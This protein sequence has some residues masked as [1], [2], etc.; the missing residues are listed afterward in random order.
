[1]LNEGV[2]M[3]RGLGVRMG[4][5]PKLVKEKAL[6]ECHLSSDDSIASSSSPPRIPSAYITSSDFDLPLIVEQVS[7]DEF[8]ALPSCASYVL[9]ANF[10]IDETAQGPVDETINEPEE[11]S[12]DVIECI[13][14][15]VSHPTAQTELE[16]EQSAF[17]RYLRR[18]MFDLCQT[19][20]GRTRQLID[21]MNTMIGLGVRRSYEH[22]T[23]RTCLSFSARFSTFPAITRRCKTS[24]SASRTPFHST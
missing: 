17:I 7:P 23:E 16:P 10:T 22:P 19:Y 18:K 11:F 14:S 24:G 13:V 8:D 5:I 3:R 2:W 4:R 21:R 1:M 9:P 6:A 15:K 20:N 12:A